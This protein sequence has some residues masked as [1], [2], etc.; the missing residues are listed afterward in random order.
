VQ[1]SSVEFVVMLEGS[2]VLGVERLEESLV[3]RNSV[4]QK[5]RGLHKALKVHI[6]DDSEVAL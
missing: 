4:I 2:R 3:G 6:G 5:D 1:D